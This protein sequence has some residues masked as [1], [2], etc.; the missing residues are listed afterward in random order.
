M[1]LLLLVSLCWEVG[2][3]AAADVFLLWLFFLLACL[4][5]EG[6][7]DNVKSNVRMISAAVDGENDA[8]AAN[9]VSAALMRPFDSEERR[10]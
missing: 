8:S 7:A 3:G 4:A 5:I 2:G 1:L 10:K 6:N 9:R